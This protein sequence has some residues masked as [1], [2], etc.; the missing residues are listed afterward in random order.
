MSRRP[1]ATR[2]RATPSPVPA[3][4][5]RLSRLVGAGTSG[6]RMVRETEK[7]IADWR[8]EPDLDAGALR[9][10]L[11][12]LRDDIAAGVTSAEEQAADVDQSDKAAVRQSGA[13]VS[14]LRAVRDAVLSAMGS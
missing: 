12:T 14:G 9:E 8:A 1:G 7:I 4:L 13:M 11:E 3:A 2:S 5:D 6:D 10:R